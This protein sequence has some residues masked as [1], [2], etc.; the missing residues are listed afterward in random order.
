[1]D[2]R[3]ASGSKRQASDALLERE[4]NERKGG[5]DGRLEPRWMGRRVAC[6]SDKAAVRLIAAGVL[7][8]GCWWR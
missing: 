6:S 7:A 5:L 3:R 8:G 4:A 1:M 2:P